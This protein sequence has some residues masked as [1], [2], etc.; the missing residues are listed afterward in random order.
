MTWKLILN[1]R[2]DNVSPIFNPDC[3]RAGE[4]RSGYQI[5]SWRPFVSLRT[6][7]SGQ[8]LQSV[9]NALRSCSECIRLGR[10][11][12]QHLLQY[13]WFLAAVRRVVVTVDFF[14]PF[15]DCSSYQIWSARR[16]SACRPSFKEE[17]N[18]TIIAFVDFG[19]EIPRKWWLC[20]WFKS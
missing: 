13:W 3:P 18:Y 12:F 17:K 4:Y 6:E 14:S 7:I 16:T 9:N 11:H 15:I 20:T 2:Y 19:D 1:R 5:A 10:K 8:E